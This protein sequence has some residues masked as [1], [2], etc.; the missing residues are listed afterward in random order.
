[1][2][3]LTDFHYKITGPENGTHWV[4]LHGLM[5]FLNN[6]Q[7][8]IA[9]LGPEQSCLTYD[10]RGHG[11]SWK[12]QTGYHPEDYSSDLKMILQSLGWQKITLVGHSMGGRN[13]LNFAARFPEVVER[14]ILEDISPEG[15]A[16]Q[17]TY[18]KNLLGVVPV[19]F[20]DRESAR[21]FFRDEF[22]QVAKTRD[23]PAVIGAF[24]NANLEEQP[25]GIMDFRFSQ[26]AIFESV[27]AGLER[28]RWD[29][30]AVLRCPTLLIR[31]E[32]SQ[33]L[34]QE[35]FER[36]QG[37]NPLIQGVIIPRAGHWVHSD[38]PQMYLQAIR[39]FAGL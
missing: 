31:G 19:P 37:A 32:N 20:P 1:M 15:R 34:S 12:P 11:R 17:L 39:Q 3:Q 29:E 33:E 28:S 16:D 2:P 14:L 36:M 10:Q 22:A 35:T 27:G 9:G 21:A 30:V 8:V 13:A 18:F 6:W 25:D 38:Q 26:K 24:L 7:K 23:N 4:F 5:G